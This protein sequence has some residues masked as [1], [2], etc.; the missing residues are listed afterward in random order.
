MTAESVCETYS[1]IQNDYTGCLLRKYKPC[2]LANYDYHLQVLV[3]KKQ[4]ADQKS[5]LHFFVVLDHIRRGGF[6]ACSSGTRQLLISYKVDLNTSSWPAQWISISRILKTFLSLQ[7]KEQI[8]H[9]VLI[10]TLTSNNFIGII[11]VLSKL[12]KAAKCYTKY[13]GHSVKAD[14]NEIRLRQT[15]FQKVKLFSAQINTLICQMF[16]F[17][18]NI[19][20]TKKHIV[21]NI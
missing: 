20:K 7:T 6:K 13:F 15:Q 5:L 3:K 11:Y 12:L 2:N 9:Q 8:L 17:C 4:Y 21:W 10:T 1:F 18:N 16:F 14:K 19:C